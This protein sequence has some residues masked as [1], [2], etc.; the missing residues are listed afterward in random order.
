MAY[1][2]PNI[3]KIVVMSLYGDYVWM[4]RCGKGYIE[5]RT[6]KMA[7]LLHMKSSSLRDCYRWCEQF[8]YISDLEIGYGYVRYRV[9]LPKQLMREYGYEI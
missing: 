9:N 6:R 3:Y 7:D 4:Q 2:P 5:V 1:R 8:K